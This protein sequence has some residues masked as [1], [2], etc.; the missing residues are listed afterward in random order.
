MTNEMKKLLKLMLAEEENEAG[1][2]S[3]SNDLL[4]VR[5]LLYNKIFD[6]EFKRE[7]NV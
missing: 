5:F 7:P 4:H 3:Q 1:Q 2:N 6:R